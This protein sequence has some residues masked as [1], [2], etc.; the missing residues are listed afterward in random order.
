LIIYFHKL[1]KMH[2]SY[3]IIYLCLL[4]SSCKVMHTS[5]D[6]DKDTNFVKLKTY[7][8]DD[9]GIA[10]L[11]LNSLDKSRTFNSVEEELKNKG[12]VKAKHPDV[13][14]NILVVKNQSHVKGGPLAGGYVFDYN[15]SDFR[16]TNGVWS[17]YG[18]V[19]E[20]GTIIIDL[21]DP[22]TKKLVWHGQ[23]D[24]FKFDDFKKREQRLRS[25][26]HS[27]LDQYPPI[28]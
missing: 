26:I 9:E 4:L 23:Y 21:I 22:V 25:A 14:V 2:K 24:G 18:N 20:G 3:L 19:N 10:K 1:N 5:S 6:F 12:F 13:L 11:N 16:W 27:I 28:Q 17:P 7:E 15:S 8:Y